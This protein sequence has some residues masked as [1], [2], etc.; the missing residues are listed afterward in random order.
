MFQSNLLLPALVMLL[1][2]GFAFST[3]ASSHLI[4]TAGLRIDP[5]WLEDGKTMAACPVCDM[6]LHHPTTGCPEG[7][8]LC[9][10]CYVT[11]LSQ[12][13]RCPICKERTDKSRLQRCRP[14]EDLIG[15]LRLR[16]KNGRA[17]VEGVGEDADMELLQST[18]TDDRHEELGHQGLDTEG[19]RGVLLAR[20]EEHRGSDAGGKWC[21]WRGKVFEL[22]EHLAESCSF[23]PI[24][25]PIAAAGCKELVL[26]K[27]AACHASETCE[28][29]PST[30]RHCHNWFEA[31]ALADH[32]GTC[33]E[34]QIDCPNAGCVETMARRSMEEHRGGCGR[35]DVACPCPG[36]E[37]RMAREEVEGH[38]AASGAVHLRRA[39]SWAAEMEKKVAEQGRTIAEQNRVNAAMLKRSEALMRVFTWNTNHWMGHTESDSY[40]FTEGVSGIGFFKKSEH[41]S[42]GYC[43]GFELEEGPTCT[44]HWKCMILDKDDKI[45]RRIS[46]PKRS[47]FQNPPFEVSTVGEGKGVHFNLTAADKTGAVRANGSIKL[48]MVVH[49]YLPE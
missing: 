22:E 2:T 28:H 7:H 13:K 27:D 1:M 47:D 39:W 11:E 48:R 6:V 41:G 38:V 42:K 40:T 25:C 32:E 9:K 34:E 45:L 46:K 29:R 10:T 15:Q 37:E 17:E 4:I 8:A 3:F 16:C 36:C 31:R 26:R 49:L 21:T 19:E 33:P 44:I 20:P 5:E 43:M 23:E 30:C 18:H 35:E 12:R 24:Q 14:L